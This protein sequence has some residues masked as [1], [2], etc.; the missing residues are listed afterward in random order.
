MAR[1]YVCTCVSSIQIMFIWTYTLTDE[2]KHLNP[3]ANEKGDADNVSA[4]TA[5]S[6]TKKMTVD[7]EGLFLFFAFRCNN[8]YSYFNHMLSLGHSCQLYIDLKYKTHILY[9]AYNIIFLKISIKSKIIVLILYSS[10]CK[11]ILLNA[12]IYW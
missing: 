5:N 12:K 6:S 3:G 2:V 10:Q 8:F 4:A 1:F 9:I 7:N 11:E